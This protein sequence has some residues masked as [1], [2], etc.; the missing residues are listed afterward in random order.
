[1]S[2]SPPRGRSGKPGAAVCPHHPHGRLPP[3]R[4][5]P[6]ATQSTWKEC[7]VEGAGSEGHRQAREVCL[8]LHREAAQTPLSTLLGFSRWLNTAGPASASTGLYPEPGGCVYRAGIL[9]GV[10][11]G[12][13]C[14]ST[15]RAPHASRTP[16]RLTWQQLEEIMPC[17]VAGWKS[18]RRLHWDPPCA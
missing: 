11:P 12:Q 10:T 17:S 18:L 1:M 9:Q 3:A 4:S 6:L 16:N 15:S 2:V 7:H 8:S 13:C 5:P 14:P